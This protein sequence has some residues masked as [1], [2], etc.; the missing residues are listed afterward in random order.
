M[1]ENTALEAVWQVY[2]AGIIGFTGLGIS[3]YRNCIM[4]DQEELEKERVRSEEFERR[5]ED[6]RNQE[7]E[8][9]RL[10]KERH[11]RLDNVTNTK[12]WS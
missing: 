2:L 1:F 6:F 9:N 8:S 5:K 12:R 7:E 3:F 4:E 11:K 10:L